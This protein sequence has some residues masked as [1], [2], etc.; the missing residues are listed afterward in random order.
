MR[1]PLAK[2]SERMSNNTNRAE[3]AN[4]NKIATLEP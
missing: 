3:I 1:L 4:C 2:I